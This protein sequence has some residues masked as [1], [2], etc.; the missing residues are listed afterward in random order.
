MA[1]CEA[2]PGVP[3]PAVLEAGRAG[4]A[5]EH[6]VEDAFVDVEPLRAGGLPRITIRFVVPVSHDAQEDASALAA[7]AAL[8]TAI[9]AVARW[10][11]LRVFRRVHGRWIELER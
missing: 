10:R 6:H 9:S 3:P 2:L 8:A 7:G 1:I 4:V 11:D 5:A